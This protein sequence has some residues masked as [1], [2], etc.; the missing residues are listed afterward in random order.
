MGRLMIRFASSLVDVAPD[1][2]RCQYACPSSE[3]SA[4]GIRRRVTVRYLTEASAKSE[5][6]TGPQHDP[7]SPIRP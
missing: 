5:E 1:G 2:G 7:E 3:N 6:I 4:V